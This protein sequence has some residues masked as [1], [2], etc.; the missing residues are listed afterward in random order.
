MATKTAGTTGTTVLTAV[1]VPPRYAATPYIS[2]ADWATIQNSI[3]DDL[4]PTHPNYPGAFTRQGLLYLPRNR[5]V[6]KLQEGDW[7]AVDLNG[8]PVVISNYSMPQTLAATGTTVSGSKAI[9]FAASVLALGWQ[10]GMPL[11]GTGVGVAAVIQAISADG[12]TVTASVV[13]SASAPVTVTVNGGGW[14]H[15]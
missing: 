14:T 11:S 2:D 8:W 12:L 7:V 9:T 4:N 1:Q 10:I 13:S 3:L 15:S 5:G 6:I